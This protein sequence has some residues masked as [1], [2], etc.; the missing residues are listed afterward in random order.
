MSRKKPQPTIPQ[1]F[2]PLSL[3][4]AVDLAT[5]AYLSAGP[6]AAAAVLRALYLTH[7]IEGS[8]EAKDWDQFIA[9]FMAN[10]RYAAKD[11]KLL[12][13]PDDLAAL[14]SESQFNA[15]RLPHEA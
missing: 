6:R 4:P 12:F 10:A 15:F 7:S 14:P 5:A 1:T 13:T 3:D 8:N 2:Q 11:G 9:C